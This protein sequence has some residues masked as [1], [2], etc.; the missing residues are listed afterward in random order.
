MYPKLFQPKTIPEL[1][2]LPKKTKAGDPNVKD[3]SYS[4]TNSTPPSG[5]EETVSSGTSKNSSTPIT[6]KSPK[7]P[8]TPLTPVTAVTPL[9]LDP[10]EIEFQL[11]SAISHQL[12]EDYLTAQ[13][14]L[15]KLSQSVIPG[16]KPRY[17][18][19]NQ[20]LAGSLG[21]RACTA[22]KYERK[23]RQIIYSQPHRIHEDNPYRIK[24]QPNMTI[25][26]NGDR[27]IAD[28]H[29]CE[30]PLAIK[31]NY[32]EPDWIE[33][34]PYREVERW[35]KGLAMIRW[36]ERCKKRH[37]E[38]RTSAYP[39]S[40]PFSRWRKQ[41]STDVLREEISTRKGIRI[42]KQGER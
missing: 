15:V 18:N 42:A 1:S 24:V 2:H 40:D 8:I 17:P 20:D 21:Y 6:P 16:R 7:S 37:A 39:P 5:E 22:P 26:W 38:A 11:V 31:S 33:Y 28:T 10:D 32:E 27:P 30:D 35:I 4:R 9:D 29:L 19:S 36:K 13:T 3:L 41:D 25:P 14:R 12:Q 34:H 23:V